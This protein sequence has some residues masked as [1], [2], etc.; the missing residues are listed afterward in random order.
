MW[1]ACYLPGRNRAERTSFQNQR[2][3]HSYLF[4]RSSQSTSF[5]SYDDITRSCDLPLLDAKARTSRG[6][7]GSHGSHAWRIRGRVHGPSNRRLRYAAIRDDR[8]RRIRGPCVPNEDDGGAQADWAV[9]AVVIF[10]VLSFR[11]Y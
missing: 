10:P 11:G 2:R 5:A 8:F 7:Y 1:T 3:G 9:S 6:S 4:A